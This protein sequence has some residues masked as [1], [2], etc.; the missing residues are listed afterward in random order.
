MLKENL[1]KTH[2]HILKLCDLLSGKGVRDGKRFG[3]LYVT[4]FNYV[5]RYK[6]LCYS[7]YQ[8]IATVQ[9]VIYKVAQCFYNK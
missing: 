3:V 5:S 7:T 2:K 6:E 9:S 8:N 4:Q 1:S